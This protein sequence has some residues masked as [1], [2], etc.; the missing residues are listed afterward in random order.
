MKKTNIGQNSEGTKFRLSIFLQYTLFNNCLREYCF[1]L[2]TVHPIS[3]SKELVIFFGEKWHMIT[4]HG[5]NPVKFRKLKKLSAMIANLHIILSFNF[6]L[7][8]SKTI[9]Q[10]IAI[11]CFNFS[12]FFW[13]LAATMIKNIF[14]ST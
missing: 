13:M 3:E 8:F 9:Y 7:N 2:Y 4:L 5:S 12:T 10:W 6:Y 14:N 1:R 11:P